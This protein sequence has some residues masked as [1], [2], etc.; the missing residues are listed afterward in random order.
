MPEALNNEGYPDIAVR[1]VVSLEMDLSQ[2]GMRK[3]LFD[4]VG[5]S[6]IEYP[7]TAD[8]QCLPQEKMIRINPK[9]RALLGCGFAL[10]LPKNLVAYV[11]ARERTRNRGLL[12]S[13][14][15][16]P[17]THGVSSELVGEVYNSSCDFVC[18]HQ[19]ERVFQLVIEERIVH[20]FVEVSWK[21]LQKSK[22]QGKSDD[23]VPKKLKK[24]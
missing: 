2:S 18:V 3:T 16:I 12:T 17:I 19:H 8:L 23:S 7:Q 21:K 24:K 13:W 20:K 11:V 14:D 5:E 4:F 1:A 10:D 9:G 22:P 6:T 15:S